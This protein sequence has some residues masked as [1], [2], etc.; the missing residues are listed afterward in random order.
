[1]SIAAKDMNVS[2]QYPLV[3]TQ[4]FDVSQLE[5]G[6]AVVV[7]KIPFNSILTGGFLL[8]DTAF[9]SNTSDSI[10]VGD[11]GGDATADPNRYLTATDVQATGRTALAPTGFQFATTGHLT[12]TW[13]GDGSG[14][15]IAS[16]GS[17]ILVYEYIT[18][19]RHSFEVVP[20]Y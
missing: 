8:I 3:G 1:M 14:G 17:G 6:V 12:L 11:D 4:R 19:G 2:R 9:D 13:T 7:A 15:D 18:E 5:S 10:I 16:V 20:S